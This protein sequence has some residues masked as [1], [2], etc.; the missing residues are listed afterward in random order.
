MLRLHDFDDRAP[1]SVRLLQDAANSLLRL[2]SISQQHFGLLAEDQ[3]VEGLFHG[4]F[5]QMAARR[6]P[7]GR[8]REEGAAGCCRLKAGLAKQLAEIIAPTGHALA[9]QGAVAGDSEGELSGGSDA[10]LLAAVSAQTLATLA[11]GDQVPATT[12]RHA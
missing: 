11:D 6:E 10:F 8:H 5:R 2:L 12:D 4:R 3:S 9:R 1:L 7:L